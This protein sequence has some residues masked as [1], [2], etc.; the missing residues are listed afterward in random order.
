MLCCPCAILAVLL[1]TTQ[2]GAQRFTLRDV[3]GAVQRPFAAAETRAVALIFIL[4]DCPIA[5]SYAP[6]IQRLEKEFG[7][8]G[9]RFFLVQVDPELTPAETRRHA[10][11]YG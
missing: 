7:T 4:P 9:V 6:E 10:R 1:A 5:N 8:Q 3:D 2:P 11:Q